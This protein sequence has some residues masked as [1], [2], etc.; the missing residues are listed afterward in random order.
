MQGLAGGSRQWVGEQASRQPNS[1][2]G[3][4]ETKEKTRNNQKSNPE[5]T[6]PLRWIQQS[7]EEWV[8]SWEP[9]HP[10]PGHMYIY[11]FFLNFTS[12]SLFPFFTACPLK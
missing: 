5:H 8:K 9:G 10:S 6:L 1:G 11:I 2:P 7:D 12:N 4:L 3:I